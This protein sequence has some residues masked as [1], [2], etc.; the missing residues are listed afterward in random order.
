MI[1]LASFLLIAM[2]VPLMARAIGSLNKDL[3]T[4]SICCPGVKPISK[5]LCEEACELSTS[6]MIAVS[7]MF[8]SEAVLIRVISN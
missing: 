4:N 3:L 1:H 7:P 8:K 5:I 2:T 6:F